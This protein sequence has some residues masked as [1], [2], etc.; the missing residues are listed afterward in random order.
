MKILFIGDIVGRPGREAVKTL[1]GSLKEELKPDFVFAN[2]ENLAGGKGVTLDTYN[3]M[4]EAGIDY[5]TSGNH[6]WAVADFVPLLDDSKV[7][8]LRPANYP[9][10]VPG[11][12]FVELDDLVLVNLLGR[13]FVEPPV[14]CPF[15]SIDTLLNK[16]SWQDK[17]IILDFHREATSESYAM[18]YHLDGRVS[19]VLGTHTHVQT[20]DEKVTEKGTAYITDIGMVGAKDSIIG[21][22]ID[23]VLAGYKT[24]L[25]M[26]F[27]MPKQ[28]AKIFNAVLVDIDPKTKKARSIERVNRE[29]E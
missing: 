22:E 15:I 13:T 18:L 29:I 20:A 26:R 23:S 21:V 17:T 3:E 4:V 16:N 5:L 7:K 27:E 10:G 19:A 1:L 11:R 9:Q 8:V 6:I 14:D 25:P 12:G 28:G 2:A 24:G